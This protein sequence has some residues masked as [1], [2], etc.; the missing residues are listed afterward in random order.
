MND[1]MKMRLRMVAGTAPIRP[2]NRLLSR[3][4]QS[5]DDTSDAVPVGPVAVA[6]CGC[7]QPGPPAP[8][9]RLSSCSCDRGPS[10][11]PQSH[12]AATRRLN[13]AVVATDHL[14]RPLSQCHTR[15]DLIT[16]PNPPRTL[17]TCC[18]AAACP[19]CPEIAQG[20]D[21]VAITSGLKNHPAGVT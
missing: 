6:A 19:P 15:N 21:V 13:S 5:G 4:G 10:M 9:D 12:R 16:C 8:R 20:P 2:A 1:E 14:A 11:T 18:I 3:V 7:C 17:V